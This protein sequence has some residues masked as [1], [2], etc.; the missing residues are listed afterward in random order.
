ME[1]QQQ[2]EALRVSNKQVSIA[3][4][5]L[6]WDEKNEQLVAAQLAATDKQSIDSI[7]ATYVTSHKRNISLKT[8]KYYWDSITVDNAQKGGA[9]FAR[10]MERINA[11]G[12]ALTIEHPA[13]ADP[14]TDKWHYFY[15]LSRKAT[16]MLPLFIERLD[17]AIA[18]PVL[19]EWGEYMYEMGEE[20][21]LIS[22]LASKGTGYESGICVT[23]NTESWQAIIE[24]GFAGGHLK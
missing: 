19:P 23:K 22:I 21:G 24:A 14:R 15:V 10:T 18:W 1:Q 7:W 6:V 16:D 9:K 12:Y 3:A 4:S 17:M 2:L 11:R 20:Q 13:C 8:G 5:Y